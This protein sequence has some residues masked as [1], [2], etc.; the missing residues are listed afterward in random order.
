MRRCSTYCRRRWRCRTAA[1]TGG[2]QR[3]AGTV[4]VRGRMGVPA[5][6]LAAAH[7]IG[8]CCCSLY[9]AYVLHTAIICCRYSV[10]IESQAYASNLKQKMVSSCQEARAGGCCQ[11]AQWGRQPGPLL[12]AATVP[13]AACHLHLWQRSVSNHVHP[14]QQHRADN[15]H[16]QPP[17]G[18]ACP[19]VCGSVLVA[20]RMEYWDFYTRAM[21]WAAA[22]L[23]KQKN[24]V[25]RDGRMG[26]D[27]TLSGGQPPITSSRAVVWP[28]KVAAHRMRGASADVF[29][30]HPPTHPP[31]PPPCLQARGGVCGGG[32]R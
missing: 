10:Y 15:E 6:H 20:P 22:L 5:G 25:S 23:S 3:R 29:P 1:T 7:Q 13:G 32:Q 16:T 14:Q 19:Q 31:L 27:F 4:I 11:P 2:A 17:P 26:G 24:S 28:R 8:A 9:C 12:P 18:P 30:T 21:R